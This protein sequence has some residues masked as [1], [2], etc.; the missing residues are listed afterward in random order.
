MKIPCRNPS[1]FANCGARNDWTVATT[2][3]KTAW[4]PAGDSTREAPSR[5]ASCGGT[6]AAAFEVESSAPTALAS[7][8]SVAGVLGIVDMNP[9]ESER[10]DNRIA[11]A[12]CVH[13][14]TVG[15]RCIPECVLWPSP[16]SDPPLECHENRRAGKLQ[17]RAA[18][19]HR[20]PVIYNTFY[21]LSPTKYKFEIT[22]E[23]LIRGSLS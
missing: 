14:A 12:S 8:C 6:A 18:G 10:V 4:R 9:T 22:Y 5:F 13:G 11:S 15:A 20:D 16:Q 3:L 23:Y 2:H 1:F 19:L 7:D 21:S 17:G